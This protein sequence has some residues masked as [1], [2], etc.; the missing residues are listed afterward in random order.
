[1]YRLMPMLVAVLLAACAAAH[2]PEEEEAARAAAYAADEATCKSYG[3]HP[4]THEFDGCMT[5]LGD[6]RARAD[7]NDRAGRLLGRPPSWATF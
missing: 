7:V 2:S 3:L 1:V 6:Q 5:K 4:G